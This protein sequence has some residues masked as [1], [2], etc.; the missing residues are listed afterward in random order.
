MPKNV[1][2]TKINKLRSDYLAI[3]SLIPLKSSYYKKGD[4][5]S[6]HNYFIYGLALFFCVGILAG[7]LT[8]FGA[9]APIISA[10]VSI[11]GA[12]M[13]IGMIALSVFALYAIPW[14]LVY[15]PTVGSKIR[16]W[17]EGMTGNKNVK[18]HTKALETA[19]YALEMLYRKE[20]RLLEKGQISESNLTTKGALI[21]L[22]KILETLQKVVYLRSDDSL[23]KLSEKL[24]KISKIT[25]LNKFK[26]DIANLAYFEDFQNI[27]NTL[28]SNDYSEAY[29]EFLDQSEKFNNYKEKEGNIFTNLLDINLNKDSIFL[30]L[31]KTVAKLMRQIAWGKIREQDEGKRFYSG[32]A[33]KLASA[34]GWIN[35]LI[36]NSTGT[37]LAPLFIFS[38]VFMVFAPTAILP[39]YLSLFLVSLF[40]LAGFVAAYGLTK[41]SIEKCMSKAADFFIDK[42]LANYKK[43]KFA[44]K[45]RSGILKKPWSY[46]KDIVK[47]YGLLPLIMSLF[48]AMGIASFNFLAGVTVGHLILNPLMLTDPI[49]VA[50][51]GIKSLTGLHAVEMFFGVVGFVFTVIAVTPLMVNAWQSFMKSLTLEPL[52][53]NK[54]IAFTALVSTTINTIL[55][56]RML[57]RPGS[58]MDLFLGTGFPILVKTIAILATVS[59]FLLGFALFYMGIKEMFA[60]R[61]HDFGTIIRDNYY[62]APSYE[63]GTKPLPKAVVNDFEL[64]TEAEFNTNNIPKEMI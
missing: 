55:L 52:S 26:T 11:L 24:E 12:N 62:L 16:S 30:S 9:A 27:L 61:G 54:G 60:H 33:N 48:L 19:H 5:T 56:A 37:A 3:A 38:A 49:A 40:G 20:I 2:Q 64:T 63:F 22:A 57:M 44:N 31:N 18:M 50:S 51:F 6:N 35:A 23:I 47:Y 53:Q 45:Y 4:S 41:A 21:Y 46:F 28:T 17:W 25:D 59:I 15:I 10:I 39:F 1:I 8:G 14:A 58:P 42:E 32:I 29:K 36:A 34:L 7:L 13:Q 43:Q